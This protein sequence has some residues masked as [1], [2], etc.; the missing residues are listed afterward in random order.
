MEVVK[1]KRQF[2]VARILKVNSKSCQ[3]RLQLLS[4]PCLTRKQ[5]W[6]IC[7]RMQMGLHWW[8]ADTWVTCLCY[9]KTLP[10]ELSVA[11][12]PL[13]GNLIFSQLF[14]LLLSVCEGCYHQ[15]GILYLV[16]IYFHSPQTL[17]N[18]SEMIFFLQK[19]LALLTENQHP[20]PS[21]VLRR[22]PRGIYQRTRASPKRTSLSPRATIV[23]QTWMR[24]SLPG[25]LRFPHL[26]PW[27]ALQGPQKVSLVWKVQT[28]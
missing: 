26:H 17:Q 2:I 10:F 28:I 1:A 4:R 6:N 14:F 23:S 24:S 8:L 18:Q 7:S 5:A 11:L 21:L 25:P 19:V 22:P 15:R 3:V 20:K 12:W 16:S 9:V 27:I 13:M